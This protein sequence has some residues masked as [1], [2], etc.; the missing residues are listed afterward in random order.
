MCASV[1]RHSRGPR[2]ARRL[3]LGLGLAILPAL[4]LPGDGRAPPDPLAALA[5]RPAVAATDPAC[6]RLCRPP[7]PRERAVRLPGSTR[8]LAGSPPTEPPAPRP[9]PAAAPT[10]GDDSP[11]TTPTATTPAATTPAGPRALPVPAPRP[12]RGLAAP[13]PLAS[14][15]LRRFRAVLAAARDGKWRRALDAAAGARSALPG[16]LAHG[17]WLAAED[18]VASADDTLRFL[19]GHPHWP[20][21][22]TIR[23]RLESR[24]QPGVSA[25]QVREIFRTDPPV[26][27]AGWL[28]L[29]LARQQQ[30]DPAG[31]LEAARIAWRDRSLGA[32]GEW[33]L[34]AAFGPELTPEDHR[35]RLDDRIWSRDWASANRQ[36]GRVPPDWRRL[37]AARITLGRRVGNA[38]RAVAAVPAALGDHPGLIYERARW[39][40][41]A[42]LDDAA[43]AL[44]HHLPSPLPAAHRW[45][46]E[47]A[48][49]IR[50]RLDAR[51]FAEAYRLALHYPSL[52]GEDRRRAAWLAGWIGLEFLGLD[53]ATAMTHFVAAREASWHPAD[54]SLA[55]YWQAR[56]AGRMGDGEREQAMLDIAAGHPAT[57][58]GQ[59]ALRA[60][61]RPLRLPPA[62]AADP[63]FLAGAEQAPAAEMI[64]ALAQADG[65]DFVWPFVESLLAAADS[66][67]AAVAVFELCREV[68]LLQH[69]LRA[70]RRAIAVHHDLPALLFLLPEEDLFPRDAVHPDLPLSVALATANQ[71]SGFD[72]TAVS[73]AGASG[74]MQ[75]MPATARQQ[76]RRL[77]LG[78]DRQRLFDDPAYNIRLGTDYLQR[79][80]VLYEGSLPLALAAYNAGAGNVRRWL[81][82]HGHPGRE[83]AALVNWLLLI[84]LA[85]TRGYVQ[86]VMERTSAYDLLLA[87]AGRA[88]ALPLQRL[89]P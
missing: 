34:L 4:H 25:E 88:A 79:R 16:R 77:A 52:A 33:E 20:G 2:L 12:E 66:P 54:V 15:D 73:H 36:L 17:L 39:R 35:T 6:P 7:A 5:A 45:W 22:E 87:P 84:P 41:R 57:F 68:G 49:H 23:R 58:F 30:G 26:T 9:R 89:L 65:D 69:A 40:R 18:A 32:R 28:R 31:A 13:G 56:A 11:A 67:A 1:P 55:A 80:I 48:L 37:G 76:A 75:L 14:A 47:L 21:R 63:A 85:E 43:R 44:L 70:V 24:L 71:E 78:W 29:A 10:A 61:G 60:L 50:D 8:S 86:R 53:P 74:L 59:L 46:D 62:P 72:P 3:A 82:R 38:D 83:E 19:A 42:G 64:R 51:D 27:G 81:R